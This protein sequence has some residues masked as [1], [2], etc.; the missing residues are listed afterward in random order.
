MPNAVKWA[1]VGLKDIIPF[2][3]WCNVSKA[4]PSS[5]VG[6]N[7]T[8]LNI[9]SDKDGDFDGTTIAFKA[10]YNFEQLV[11][12]HT[13]YVLFGSFVFESGV[14]GTTTNASNTTVTVEA[15]LRIRPITASFVT[16]ALTWNN[17]VVSPTLTIGS[18][19]Y[20]NDL[21][22]SQFDTPT[23]AHNYLMYLNDGTPTTC[24]FEDSLSADVYGFI[25]DMKATVTGATTHT[26]SATPNF[27]L[28]VKS[29]FCYKV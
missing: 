19:L 5:N 14:Q 18:A 17:V 9:E 11:A 10:I 29:P 3:S 23:T 16:S 28:A 1:P 24:G 22:I 21:L 25:L 13:A 2:K 8:S 7:G 12:N 26:F 15:N 6:L 20:T 4:S 27:N